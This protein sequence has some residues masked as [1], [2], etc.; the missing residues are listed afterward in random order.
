MKI[1]FLGI[2]VPKNEMYLSIVLFFIRFQYIF[3]ASFCSAKGIRIWGLGF[4][5]R[6]EYTKVENGKKRQNK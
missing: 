1:L 3:L 5:Q 4:G 6:K 2:K